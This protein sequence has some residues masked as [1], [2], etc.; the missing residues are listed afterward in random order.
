MSDK[1]NL[2]SEFDLELHKKK[3]PCYLE[4]VITKEGEIMYAVPSHQEKALN[5]LC[6]NL[7]KTRE[8]VFNMC[9]KEYY[10]DLLTWICTISGLVFVWYEQV[11]CV[12]PSKKQIEA[13]T[14]LKESGVY[15]GFVPDE[16]CNGFTY[17]NNDRR[18]FL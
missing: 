14:T 7:N 12:Q 5:L 13:I 8:E 18:K 17:I 4:V 16:S 6:K 1:Y 9:P 15:A 2:Y 10:A 3:Y 11:F